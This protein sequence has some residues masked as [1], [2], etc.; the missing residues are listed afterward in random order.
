M[1]VEKQGSSVSH[2]HLLHL[3]YRWRI[4]VILDQDRKRSYRPCDSEN[5]DLRESSPR[6]SNEP[7]RPSPII[8]HFRDKKKKLKKRLLQVR[9]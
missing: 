7:Y 4:S 8:S 1:K 3:Q 9:E 6:D 5:H 2:A